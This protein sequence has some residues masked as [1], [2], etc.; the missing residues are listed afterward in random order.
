MGLTLRTLLL[1]HETM[2]YTIENNLVKFYDG[3]RFVASYRTDTLKRS[4]GPLMI[5]QWRIVSN[6]M[7]DE[8]RGKL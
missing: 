4:Y 1:E 8:I 7:M 6:D 5:D 3:S 2:T